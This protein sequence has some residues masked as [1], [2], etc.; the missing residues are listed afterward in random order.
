MYRETIETRNSCNSIDRH[1]VS[2][3]LQIVLTKLG[4]V[5]F[6]KTD[7]VQ[8]NHFL[9]RHIP[10]RLCRENLISQKTVQGIKLVERT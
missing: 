7:F 3:K 6:I 8:L 1:L 5:A 2:L 4:I 10:K 9:H